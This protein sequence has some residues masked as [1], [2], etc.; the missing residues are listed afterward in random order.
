LRMGVNPQNSAILAVAFGEIGLIPAM[1]AAYLVAFL[2]KFFQNKVG[3]GLDFILVILIAVPIARWFGLLI[4]AIVAGSL[5]RF[6]AIIEVAMDASRLVMGLMLGG[7]VTVVGTAP[8]SSMVLTAMLGL[9][10]APMAVAALSAFGS[11]F[12][13]STLLH[14]LKIGKI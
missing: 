11:A 4:T 2:I 6:S 9:T 14:K 7:I 12:I 5:L 13:N 3:L 1:F 8:L 10:G